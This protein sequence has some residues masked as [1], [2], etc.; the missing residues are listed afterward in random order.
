MRARRAL[1]YMPG[2]DRHK[3]EKALSLGVDCICMDM[4]DGVALNRKA[5]SLPVHVAVAT[6]ASFG[7]LARYHLVS[8]SPVAV[9][10]I[11]GTAPAVACSG[12]T[13]AFDLTLEPSS[14]TV[15]V[16]R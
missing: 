5:A 15:M 2:D 9:T 10:A 13:C 6:S 7:S 1:L 14:V 11:S 3:I 16:L 12:G 8:A 4:E